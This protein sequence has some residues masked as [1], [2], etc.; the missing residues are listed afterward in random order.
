MRREGLLV[1]LIAI[2]YLTRHG[3]AL[4]GHTEPEGN[5]H[6]LLQVWSKDNDAVKNRLQENQFTSHQFVNELLEL[7][8]L[9]ALRR[10]LNRIKECNGPA[11]F[12]IIADEATDVNQTEQV[13]LSILWDNDAYEVHEDPVGLIRVPDTKAETRFKVIKDVLVQ[14]NLPLSL[15]RGQAY[16]G[17]ANMQGRRTGVATRIRAEEPA[18]IP[19]HCCAH[20]LNLSLQDAAHQLVCVR[21]ALD[22]SRGVINMINL[23]LKRLHLFSTSLTVRGGSVTLKPLSTTT[24]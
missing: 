14:C 18:V 9:A 17:T 13:N 1:Q 3:T 4:R 19:V 12:S 23:S 5:L 6:Q 11:W 10:V 16:D 2:L 20:S 24:L 8:G 22:L 7:L 21:D 15:C